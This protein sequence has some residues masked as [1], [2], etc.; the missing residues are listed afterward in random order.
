MQQIA[1]RENCS[2]NVK[3]LSI[4]RI[5]LKNNIFVAPLAG[6]SDFAFRKMCYHLGAGLCFTE[7][8]SAKGLYYNSE[9]TASLLYTT[10]S[11]YVKAVQ[12]FGNEPDIIT[13]VAKSNY[14]DK[15]D[16]IDLNCGCPVPKVYNNGEGSALLNTPE[17]AEKIILGLKKSGKIVTLKMREGLKVGEPKYLEFAKRMEGAGVDLITFHAR[18][19]E[20]YYSGEPDY[21]AC[22]NL[23]KAV[24]IPVIFNGGV[25]SK[26]DFDCALDKTEADG[27]MLARGVLAKP[28]LISEILG[29]TVE[30]KNA[31]IR[32]QIKDLLEKYEE[33]FVA[34][35]FRKQFAFYLK[36]VKN[37]KRYKEL[38]FSATTTQTY[39]DILNE[40][41]LV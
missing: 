41:E 38:I 34:R 37:A 10:D 28:W 18:F 19:R 12:L 30:D 5:S 20:Q 32:T 7:M 13:F 16:V 3:S 9:N 26:Q 22:K 24:K 8:V 40:I 23:K 29:K 14:L 33:N 31:V 21:E 6:Y 39:F 27:V 4:G 35:F 17:I 2:L 25:F 1:K 15:F 36:N 11:E